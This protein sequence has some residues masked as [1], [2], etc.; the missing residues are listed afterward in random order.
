MEIHN[1][2]SPEI[3]DDP[4]A[5][6]I[7]RTIRDNRLKTILEIGASSGLG[8]TQA[9]VR[10]IEE[11]GLQDVAQVYCIEASRERCAQFKKNNQGIPYLHLYN[12]CS[13]GLDDYLTRDRIM[14]FYNLNK[15]N[16]N[17]YP[18]E[19]VLKWREE[20]I[21]YIRKNRIPLRG[22]QSI[23]EHSELETFDF[24]LIDGSAFTGT[25]EWDVV[26]AEW[27]CLDDINDIKNHD[28]YYRML[29]SGIYDLI[30]ENWDIRNGYA[31]FRRAW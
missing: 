1:I 11:A 25:S 26:D 9:I 21:Q 18:L 24:V 3:I 6:L 10:G 27:I 4:L 30:E 15:V 28:T 8:S 7:T 2:I 19:T 14:E 5:D 13:V 16:L 22:I 17:K 31:M 20:E 12:Y 29:N 23:K